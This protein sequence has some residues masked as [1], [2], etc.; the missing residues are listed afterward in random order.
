MHVYVDGVGR[1]VGN[2]EVTRPDVGRAFPDWGPAHG[3]DLTIDGIPPG[4]RQVCTYGISVGGARTRDSVAGPSRSS[5]SVDPSLV[6]TVLTADGFDSF[7]IHVSGGATVAT[8]PRSNVGENTRIAFR[9]AADV[10]EENE[11]SCARWTNESE[12]TDQQGVALRISRSPTG[13]R[14]AI[15]ITKNVYLGVPWIF[16]ADLWDTGSG[17]GITQIAAFDLRRVFR[18]GSR[19]RPLPWSLCALVVDDTLSF[20]AWTGDGPL[21][22]LERR[23]ARR[24]RA[25]TT[26]LGLRGAP[27][28]VCQPSPTRR[29][30][31]LHGPERRS[32]HD[33]QLDVHGRAPDAGADRAAHRAVTWRGE[34]TSYGTRDVH[35]ARRSLKDSTSGATA[36]PTSR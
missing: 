2:A 24:Q 14:R 1:A 29:L 33:R 19:I 4:V 7:G 35:D 11:I 32:G 5:A 20:V 27:R 12:A 17:A 30:D 22:G 15:T 25:P 31:Q 10:I 13:T 6:R 26:G 36:P 23:D 8:V 21:P 9:R 28:L 18:T 16:N 3:Y 34:G